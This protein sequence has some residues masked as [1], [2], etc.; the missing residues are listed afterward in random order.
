MLIIALDLVRLVVDWRDRQLIYSSPECTIWHLKFQKKS[1]MIPHERGD[2]GQRTRTARQCCDPG[3]P[4]ILHT[5][6]PM[7]TCMLDSRRWSKQTNEQTKV[8]NFLRF[9]VVDRFV[10]V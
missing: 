5:F 3:G 4:N 2:H 7:W 1:E 6:T 10:G 9:S 8:F